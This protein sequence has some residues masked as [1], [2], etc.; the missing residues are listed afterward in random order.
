[1]EKPQGLE[2]S[3]SGQLRLRSTRVEPLELNGTQVPIM[4]WT[5]Q[6]M[7]LDA[8]LGQ[9]GVGKITFQGDALDGVLLGDNG[10]FGGDPTS[11]SGISL[12]AKVPN[13]TRWT[14][15]LPE[16]GDPFDRESYVP[17]LE[18][19]PAFEINHL[20]GDVL[21]PIGLLRV[22]RQP[23]AIGPSIAGHDGGRHNRWGASNFSDTAD[24]ILFG[25]KLDE[26]IKLAQNPDH[27]IDASLD[28]GVVLGLFYDFLKQDEVQ[29]LSDDLRQM[30]LALEWRKKESDFGGFA[31]RDVLIGTRAVYLRNE[32]FDTDVVGLPFLLHVGV[33]NLDFDF[34]YIHTRGKT[35]EISEGFAAL[36][37]AQPQR[38]QLTAHGARAVADVD[39]GRV[40][41][42]MEFDYATGDGDPR[43]STPITSFSFARDMNVGLLLFEHI[44]A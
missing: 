40:V 16:G 21:L 23:I 15:G 14:V 30:G 12:S 34:Q 9:P 32:Q 25:T 18:A 20:Y 24:R 7:R 43:S 11:N 31:W 29:V 33:E 38:Q 4:Q 37:S 10:S 22:G 41:L 8:S 19:A 6:R 3:T 1:D 39:L 26:A 35:R 2:Y 28:S 44:M 42:T 5:E 36:S 17:V 13:L 27:I